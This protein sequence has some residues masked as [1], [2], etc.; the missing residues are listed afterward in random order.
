MKWGKDKWNPNYVFDNRKNC[1]ES[2][3]APCKT[4]CPA[5][6]AIQGYIKLAKEGRYLDAL[7]LIKQDNPFPSV[8]G[9]VCNRRCEDACTRGSLDKA[10]AIDEIKKF[11]AEQDLK[12]DERYI[13]DFIRRRP[14]DKPYEE[15]VAIIGAGPAG[16]SCAYYLARMGYTNVTVFDRNPQPGGMLIMGI[17]SYRLDRSALKGE[18]EV[19]E[20]MG[21]KFRMNTEVG[22]DVTIEQL[23]AD[24]YKGFYVAIGAQ[25]SSKLGI[26]GEDLDGVYGGVDFLREVNLGGSPEI[27]KKCAVIGGGNVAM[28]VCRTAI[29]LGAETTVIYRRSEEEMPA[30]KEEIAEA[31]EEGV[32]FCFLNAPVEILGTDGKVTGIKVEIM[33]LG[34]PDEKGRRK[35]VGTGNYETI[36]VDSVLAAVGQAID[37][38]GLDIGKLL[39]GKKGNALADPVT[40]QTEQPDIFV[41]GDVFTGPKFAIDAIA[42]GREGAESLHRFVQD[43]QSL[44]RGRNLREFY[45]LNKEELVFGVDSFDKPARQAIVHDTK[46]ARTFEHDRLTFTEEQVKTEASRCLGC[47]VS[48]VDQNKCIGCGLCT[49]K[50]MFDA[51]HLQRDVPEASTMVRCEDKVGPMLKHAAKQSIRII[52]KK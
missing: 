39:T 20:K 35:P 2:G 23:R 16:L 50:C 34:E 27:G 21:V 46:K 7:K 51:I 49:T 13:P 9:Y 28:D 42:A 29:R 6:I 37:W 40:Y 15:K 5:H 3:T 10:V 31:K 43:G 4:A 8:C 33:E 14:I 38:G 25:K 24:G 52:R 48:I 45:E 30:D 18:I 1:H 26:P 11:I 12:S 19:L 22:K 41:G 44:T 36:E 47:G 32:K 17:P